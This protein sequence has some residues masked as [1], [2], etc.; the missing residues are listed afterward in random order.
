VESRSATAP[1][2]TATFLDATPIWREGRSQTISLVSFDMSS[3]AQR[4]VSCRASSHC[5][6][7]RANTDGTVR[8]GLLSL[9]FCCCA[10]PLPAAP[11][12]TSTP[13]ATTPLTNPELFFCQSMKLAQPCQTVQRFGINARVLISRCER[14]SVNRGEEVGREASGRYVGSDRSQPTS[15]GAEK[16]PAPG[17]WRWSR[18]VGRCDCGDGRHAGTRYKTRWQW[19]SNVLANVHAIKLRHRGRDA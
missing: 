13:S 18:E 1:K 6:S 12:Q 5:T 2:S 4:L 7:S 8:I 17:L 16:P 14:S 9:L 11:H 19:R 15:T 3:A 10:S